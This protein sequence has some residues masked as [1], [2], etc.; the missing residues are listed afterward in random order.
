M[1]YDA[2][3]LGPYYHDIKSCNLFEGSYRISK[4]DSL[5]MAPL[6]KKIS[7]NIQP[8][9][10]SDINACACITSSAFSV[11]PHTI[12]KQLGREPFDM[13][14]ISRSGFLD[15]LDRKT[16]IY[17]KAV[18]DET[19]EIVG[20]AGWAFR[21]LDQ[22]LIPWTGPG[23]A[24]PTEEKQEKGQGKKSVGSEK[25]EQKQS[26]EGKEDSID[27]LHALEDA[28]MQYWLSHMVATDMPCMIVIGLIVSPSH[29]S[30]GVGG[31][32]MR[33]GN[34]IADDLGIPIWVHS[35]HQAYEAYKRFGFEA[36]R[37]LDI[38]L[39]E[40]APR[41]P[42]DGEEVMGDKGSG[43]WGRYVIRYMKRTPT[44]KSN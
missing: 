29:Q 38:D 17:I 23:D 20:H 15:T 44:R 12:V 16:Y 5:N 2:S 30:R 24:K 22:E 1:L 36:M 37:E 28:D 10:Y 27:R 6:E 3:S 34:A 32:L 9:H 25:K 8:L 4:A 35:S 43:K 18:D 40:Y 39:D 31:A 42:R 13:Y 21:G 19:G 41:G 11:D 26:G 33:H 14:T 7:V